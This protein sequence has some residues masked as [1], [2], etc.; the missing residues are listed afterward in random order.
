[1]NCNE[2]MKPLQCSTSPLKEANTDLFL[3]I[4][5]L[6]SKNERIDVACLLLSQPKYSHLLSLCCKIETM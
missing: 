2:I 1:M 3:F 4:I 5:K 6:I